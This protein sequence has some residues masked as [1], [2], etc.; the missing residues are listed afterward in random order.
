MSIRLPCSDR[1]GLVKC[2]RKRFNESQMRHNRNDVLDC[3]ENKVVLIVPVVA[4]LLS[5]D[6]F[7]FSPETKARH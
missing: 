7:W 5:S 1:A 2:D 4:E 6:A 3:D